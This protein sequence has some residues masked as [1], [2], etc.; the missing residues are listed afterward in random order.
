[1]SSKERKAKAILKLLEDMKWPTLDPHEPGV[2]GGLKVHLGSPTRSGGIQV[3]S[4]EIYIGR[5][6]ALADAI[7][8]WQHTREKE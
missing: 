7:R 4:D 1:M 6:S 3:G 8:D 5:Y 2:H